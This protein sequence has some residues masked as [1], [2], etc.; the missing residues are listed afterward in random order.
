LKLTVYLISVMNNPA[1]DI[2]VLAYFARATHPKIWGNIRIENKAYIFWCHN[3]NHFKFKR[4]RDF[5]ITELTHN[6]LLKNY[7]KISINIANDIIPNFIEKLKERLV[8]ARLSNAI[9][10]E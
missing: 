5:T 2:T 6:K 8:I 7:T 4:Y 3:G 9:R 1:F 10:N